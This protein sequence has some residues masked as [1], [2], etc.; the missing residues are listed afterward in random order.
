A[1]A[2]AGR[3]RSRHRQDR[4]CARRDRDT[5]LDR[6]LD[7]RRSGRQARSNPLSCPSITIA[8][9]LVLP[10]SAHWLWEK[11]RGGQLRVK[12]LWHARLHLD[13]HAVSVP[14]NS[15]VADEAEVAVEAVAFADDEA[16]EPRE[17]LGGDPIRGELGT[18]FGDLVG[19][20]VELLRNDQV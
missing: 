9:R 3:D 2:D 10:R 12:R 8:S 1:G 11:P 4:R 18:G 19:G 15:P 5:L 16:I 13:V 20:A 7:D 14:A 17:D 6:P